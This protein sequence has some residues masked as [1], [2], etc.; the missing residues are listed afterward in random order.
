MIKK[1]RKLII[2]ISILAGNLLNLEKSLHK[3][4]LSRINNIHF[5]V[6]DGHFVKN[7][8][9][10]REILEKIIKKFPFFKFNIHFMIKNPI[11]HWNNFVVP[12]V[13]KMIFHIESIKSFTNFV[14]MVKKIKKL[15]IKVGIAISPNTSIT[16]LK[17]IV[18]NNQIDLILVMTV[19]PGSSGQRFQSSNIKKIKKISFWK[20]KF[21]L[22]FLI[23]VDGGI[24]I[25]KIILCHKN[26]AN[27]FVIGSAFFKFKNPENFLNKILKLY[28]IHKNFS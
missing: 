25:N 16:K 14:R 13:K 17:K 22:K 1:R 26:G 10:G 21:N 3:I 7:I 24:N 18:I 27:F 9:F 2:S 12:N 8:S 19:E 15:G 20:K 6:M 5:D 4:S 28:N 11:I 23:G